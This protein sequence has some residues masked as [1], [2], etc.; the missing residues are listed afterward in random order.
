[1]SNDCNDPCPASNLRSGMHLSVIVPVFNEQEM[2]ERTLAAIHNGAADAEIVVVDGGSTDGSL[3]IARKFADQVVSAPRG[4]ARQQ[5][6]GAL[7]SFGDV[8]VFVHADTIVPSTFC[9]D[10]SSA[11]EN[12]R[13]CGGRFDVKLDG[14][15]SLASLIGGLISLRSRLTR[16]GTGDQAIFVRRAVV[17]VA[18]RVS[19]ISDL[20]GCSPHAPTQM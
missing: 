8:L 11:L 16:S 15:G 20:R 6:Y 4:R 19:A 5:N 18:R 2:L 7:R 1:M 10:I 14:G 17:R 3:Y 12:S 9:E 13:V